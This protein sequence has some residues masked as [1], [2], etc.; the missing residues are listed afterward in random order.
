[1]YQK[2]LLRSRARGLYKCVPK[3]DQLTN[4][5]LTTL[6]IIGITEPHGSADQVDNGHD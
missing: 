6:C 1:L 5:K 3:K 2:Y 4:L